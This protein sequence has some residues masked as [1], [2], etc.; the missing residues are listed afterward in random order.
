MHFAVQDQ[1]A[2]VILSCELAVCDCAAMDLMNV[3]TANMIGNSS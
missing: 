3:A 2:V 1:P